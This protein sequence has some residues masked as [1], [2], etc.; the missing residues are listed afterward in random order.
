MSS[1][2]EEIT[3]KQWDKILKNDALA[4]VLTRPGGGGGHIVEGDLLKRPK[5]SR[6]VQ[7]FATSY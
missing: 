3:R 2:L 1:F 7:Q 6:D 5:V 4:A